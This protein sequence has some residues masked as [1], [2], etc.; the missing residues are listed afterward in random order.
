MMIEHC[1]AVARGAKL[2]VGNKREGA[3]YSPTVLD[4]VAPV[5]WSAI[6]PNS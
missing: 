5:T 3:L 4:A 2:L 6:R 1:E